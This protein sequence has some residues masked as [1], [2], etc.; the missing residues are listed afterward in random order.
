MAVCPLLESAPGRERELLQLGGAHMAIPGSQRHTVA[1]PLGGARLD[2]GSAPCAQ[3]TAP[4]ITGS[5]CRARPLRRETKQ[6]R[7]HRPF[8]L[9]HREQGF[10]DS[11]QLSSPSSIIMLHMRHVTPPLSGAL[12]VWWKHDLV[13]TMRNC[14]QTS[15]SEDEGASEA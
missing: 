9:P 2:V 11:N 13:L 4:N 15:L 10:P 8:S 3:H 1:R 5:G 6:V 12:Q 7:E 14:L